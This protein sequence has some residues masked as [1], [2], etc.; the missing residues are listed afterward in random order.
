MQDVQ[1]V[2]AERSCNSCKRSDPAAFRFS[3][4]I[5]ALT[6]LPLWGTIP[7]V[8][9]RIRVQPN[10]RETAIERLSD[11][12]LKIK[13]TAP[14]HEGKANRAVVEALA[15]HFSVPKNRVRILTGLT[16]RSKL[17]EIE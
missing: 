17:V 8:K 13:V 12:S 1:F 15:E 2:Q 6:G 4:L 11:G 5:P 7:R 10:A 16:S 3:V 9:L 14:A